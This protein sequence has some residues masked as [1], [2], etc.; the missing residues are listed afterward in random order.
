MERKEQQ[1]DLKEEHRNLIET[2]SHVIQEDYPQSLQIH[3][4]DNF[5]LLSINIIS[6]RNH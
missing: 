1:F 5:P 2:F 4:S 6:S 3:N